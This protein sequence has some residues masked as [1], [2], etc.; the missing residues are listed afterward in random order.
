M[1]FYKFLVLLAALFAINT[2]A[3]N[4][5]LIY[6]RPAE[7]NLTKSQNMW[8]YVVSRCMHRSLVKIDQFG[9]PIADL[10]ESWSISQQGKKIVFQVKSGQFH[11]GR[12]IDA[13]DFVYSISSALKGESDIARLL[14]P[15]I[16]SV[17]ASGEREVTVQLNKKFEPLVRILASIDM[18]IKPKDSWSEK[19][20]IGAGEYKAVNL[21]E[22]RSGKTISLESG[23][24]NGKNLKIIYS[25]DLNETKGLIKK[26]SPN[27][28]FG[29]PNQVASEEIFPKRYKLE[30]LNNLTFTFLLANPESKFGKNDS[31]RM[32]LARDIFLLS[33][34]FFSKNKI[35][36]YKGLECILPKEV[37]GSLCPK[38]RFA[39]S[40]SGG[41][42]K[43][44]LGYS[45]EWWPKKFKEFIEQA[46]RVKSYDI[47]FVRINRATPDRVRNLDLIP[48]DYI[49]TF[50]DPELAIP[51][52]DV[53]A[54]E[55]KLPND[56]LKL[57]E[58]SSVS[59]FSSAKERLEK[60]G[61][62]YASFV[63]RGWA[64]PLFGQKVA[65]LT[66]SKVPLGE[67]A[68]QF[69]NLLCN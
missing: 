23:S 36:Q 31:L 49:L 37:F 41:R 33:K 54:F 52:L 17:H 30:F 9:K 5:V 48:S 66:D 45:D 7:L 22:I 53:G 47:D 15:L 18:A 3:E 57:K 63:S 68:Y 24:K 2:R 51:A 59:K 64:I 50:S 42:F 20:W 10:A 69:E 67:S 26:L 43:I 13:S 60:F 62:A 44:R 32:I 34:D 55:R 16:R 29:L 58:L 8:D 4:L 1:E 6:S 35:I 19:P 46:L 25:S 38:P 27:L 39:A 21:K 11:D 40:P 56:F 12:P 14:T 28:I 65:I 61:K